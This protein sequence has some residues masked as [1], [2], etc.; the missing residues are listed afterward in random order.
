MTKNDKLI[1]SI[2]IAGVGVLVAMAILWFLV[3]QSVSISFVYRET[4]I[5][6]LVLSYV[7]LSLLVIWV[8]MRNDLIHKGAKLLSRGDQWWGAAGAV[9]GPF[10]I[11]F[12]L[13]LLFPLV[14][15]KFANDF[16]RKQF[17][18]VSTESYARTSRGLVQLKLLTPKAMSIWWCLKS[19]ARKV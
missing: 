10:L 19:S 17:T 2:F 15:D 11:S 9:I 12:M 8:L 14:A 7:Q 6:L 1:R 18:Y 3:V 16:A 5:A 13:V 4:K